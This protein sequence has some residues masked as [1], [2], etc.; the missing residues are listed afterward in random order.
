[1]GTKIQ[2]PLNPILRNSARSQRADARIDQVNLPVTG[3]FDLPIFECVWDAIQNGGLKGGDMFQKGWWPTGT[4][5]EVD[6]IQ[7]LPGLQYVVDEQDIEFAFIAV[8]I[9]AIKEGI[10]SLNKAGEELEAQINELQS[11]IDELKDKKS[12][13]EQSYQDILKTLEAAE[14]ELLKL[15]KVCAEEPSP[16]CPAQIQELKDKIAKIKAEKAALQAELN[17]LA[18]E[19]FALTQTLDGLEQDREN[20]EKQK[21]ES[22][23]GLTLL[24]E[25]NEF[26]QQAQD[27]RQ[28]TGYESL[29]YIVR[30]YFECGFPQVEGPK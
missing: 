25:R 27:A 13:V 3:K 29:D 5:R 2:S 17:K 14:Q 28:K 24:E 9:K 22:E 15:E 7:A 20:I 12:D 1:M 11:Q 6:P 16:E 19:I 18:A 23:I 21:K 4:D 8:R 30:A 26:L 10:E